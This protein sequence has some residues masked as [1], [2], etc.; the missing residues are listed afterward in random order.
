[1]T[2]GRASTGLRY[3]R[4]ILTGRSPGSVA[5][6]AQ[7]P[8]PGRARAFSGVRPYHDRNPDAGRSEIDMH[9]GRWRSSG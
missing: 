7:V 4:P 3:P 5:G 1:M 2:A 8:R 6:P 9:L